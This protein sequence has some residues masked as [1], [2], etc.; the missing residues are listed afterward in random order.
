MLF[1]SPFPIPFIKTATDDNVRP[2]AARKYAAKLASFGMASHFYET[3]G[4]QHALSDTPQDAAYY[5]AM[6]YTY[7]ADRLM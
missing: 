6:L 1:R 5:D 4:G 3:A 7:L 2:S